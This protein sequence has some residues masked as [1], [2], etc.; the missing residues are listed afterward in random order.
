MNN[1]KLLDCT[2]RDG[3]YI[4][5]S[6]FGDPAIKGI[7]NKLQ[8]A[9][10]EIIEC[11]WLKNFEHENG[12]SFFHIPS[13]LE[14]YITTKN[15]NTTYVV[16]IDWDRYDINNLPLNN[17]KSID[18]IRVVFPKGKHKQGIAVGEE[19]YK[20][21]YRVF[22]QAAN[23]LGYSEDE[24]IELADDINKSHTVGLSVVDTFGAMYE[25]D[26]EKILNILD[27]RLKNE[28]KLGF[29]SHNNQQLSF[30]LTTSFLKF[31]KNS[32]R[33]IIIDSS[34]C[35]MGRGAGN[36]TTE[37]VVSYLNK[38]YD[39]HYNLDEIMDAIDIY[40]TYFKENYSWGYS[41]EY[42]ISGLYC[43]H[44]NNIA[45]LLNNHHTTAK[46]M[47]NIIESLSPEDRKKYDYDL[48]EQ[49]Y[50]ENQ[51][52]YVDDMSTVDLLK[53]KLNNRKVLMIAPGKTSVDDRG[54]I[55]DYIN[56]NKPVVIGVN[57]IIPEYKYDY[58]FF[59][60]PTR[61]EYAQNAYS[62]EFKQTKHIILSNIKNTVTDNE[63][64]INYESIIRRG[65]PH[66][67]NA[68]M[69]CLYL[70]ERL[71]AENVA[72]A[73]FDGFKNKYNE[74][75]ADKLLPSLNLN[76]DWDKLNEEIHRMF[77]RFKETAEKCK[78]IEF[79]TK[80]IFEAALPQ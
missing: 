79:V 64:L 36:A 22:Y 6:E 47:R 44:V 68:V 10:V 38:K 53:R 41:T 7:I 37:L 31:F 40:M 66:F 33:E 75:Y 21:G 63:L 17:G 39:A 57:A 58:L 52:R 72:I 4:V 26:L 80:S 43:C 27:K 54:R 62:E 23:T 71:D 9:N 74:S 25:E 8:N 16:M 29:H 11:G 20:K 30:S 49:K 24:L 70:L 1:I 28:I 50:V 46:D 3:A 56:K 2:L 76:G 67:D 32:N 34:L 45:Y 48:L 14:Q 69:C 19:I 55:Q 15:K 60:N 18:A 5:N 51:S 12:S 13:D 73:G 42:F 35:G 77:I 78:K 59:V 61:Y 65:W